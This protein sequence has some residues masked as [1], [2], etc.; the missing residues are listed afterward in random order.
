MKMALDLGK[1]SHE[2]AYNLAKCYWK[3]GKFRET[4]QTA[5]IAASIDPAEYRSYELA[6][7]AF[8]RLGE[9]GDAEAMMREA[10]K[11]KQTCET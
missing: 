7:N 2:I 5:Q 1:G 9:I 4:A 11:L 10:D 3:L 8:R 6:A